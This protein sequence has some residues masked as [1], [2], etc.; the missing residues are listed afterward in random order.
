MRAQNGAEAL[1]KT[2]RAPVGTGAVFAW[3]GDRTMVK[4]VVGAGRTAL[5]R[6]I[7]SSD[8]MNVFI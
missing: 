5:G 4:V 3:P 7:A 1:N 8:N 6:P 2:T